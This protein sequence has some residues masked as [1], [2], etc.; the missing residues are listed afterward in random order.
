MHLSRC[1]KLE[2]SLF[3]EKGQAS[4]LAAS[5]LCLSSDF[6]LVIWDCDGVLV[7]SEA[8]L[9]RVKLMHWLS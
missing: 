1:L 2:A 5:S 9:R 4:V 8:L 3:E 7:D 6:D